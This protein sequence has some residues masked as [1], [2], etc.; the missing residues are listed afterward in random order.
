M[1]KLQAVLSKLFTKDERDQRLA[2]AEQI[3]DRQLTGPKPGRTS[4]NL[5][6]TEA[7]KLIDTLDGMTREQ[8]V[9]RLAEAIQ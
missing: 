2:A 4:S 7:S 8:L 3:I 5:S 1:R 6:Y 9:A